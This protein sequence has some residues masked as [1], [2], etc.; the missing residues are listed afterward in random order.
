MPRR[1]D[2]I[3]ERATAE[4]TRPASEVLAGIRSEIGGD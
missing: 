4:S 3:L 1:L 2:P